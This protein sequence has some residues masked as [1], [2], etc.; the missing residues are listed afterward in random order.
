MKS[1]FFDVDNQL[2]F[3]Y[4]AG[5]LYVPGAEDLLP[6]LAKLTHYAKDNRIQIVS[7]ADAHAEDDVEF[8]EWKPHC[9]AGTVG[10]Q[11]SAATL[12]IAQPEVLSS[13]SRS[14]IAGPSPQ[15]IV[16]K[17]HVDCFTNPNL[18]PLLA[19]MQAERYVVYGVVSEICVRCAVF[20]LLKTKVRVELV[21]DAIRHLNQSAY[22]AMLGEFRSEGG[23]T[24][25]SDEVLAGGR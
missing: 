23:L 10:Q 11:K 6:V 13:R 15:I 25:K 21:T 22:E 7:T 19:S 20:G 2:D 1:I 5:A 14:T 18:E 3:L 17:Q 8:A 16:E 12:A 4:P 9:V 24:V